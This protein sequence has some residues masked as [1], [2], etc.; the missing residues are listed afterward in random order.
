MVQ[1]PMAASIN[2]EL[3]G[4]RLAVRND[5]AKHAGVQRRTLSVDIRGPKGR[6][7]AQPKITISPPIELHSPNG[8]RPLKLGRVSV[9]TATTKMRCSSFSLPAGPPS[10]GGTCPAAGTMP[11]G[12]DPSSWICGG[13]YATTG[14]YRFASVQLVQA[15]RKE[16]V[17]RLMRLGMND[18]VDAISWALAQM[19]SSPRTAMIAL[20][21]DRKA[22]VELDRRFFRIHDSGDFSWL[23]NDYIMAWAHVAKRF[24]E[25]SF[26]APTRDWIFKAKLPALREAARIAP[27]L[28]IRPSALYVDEKPPSVPGLSGGT[29]VAFAEP[30]S[31]WDCPAYAAEEH[32]CATGINPRGGTGCRVCWVDQ[33]RPVNYKPHGTITEKLVQVRVRKNPAYKLPLEEMFGEFRASRGHAESRSMFAAWLAEQNVP[34]SSFSE[35]EWLRFLLKLGLSYDQAVTYLE[36]TDEWG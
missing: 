35:D 12:A 28:S 23:G 22:R 9:F 24:P 7:V 18:F 3:F 32:S 11:S 14:N 5:I 19:L 1:E 16:W 29:S 20:P 36:A 25:V 31:V 6:G 30:K 4:S 26:W 13:C 8:G 10:M 21:G 33:K 34:P 17:A 27:N 2:R 15:I